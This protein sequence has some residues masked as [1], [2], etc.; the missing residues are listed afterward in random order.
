MLIITGMSGAGKSRVMAAL[1]DIGYFCVDNLP[2]R[3]APTFADL[4]KTANPPRNDAAVV[5]DS[6]AGGAFL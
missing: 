2:P 3:L 4:L 1:E 5:M 6:R